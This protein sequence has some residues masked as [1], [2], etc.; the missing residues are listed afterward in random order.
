MRIKLEDI[1]LGNQRYRWRQNVL[2]IAGKHPSLR[3]YLG[4]KAT[5]FPGQ[6]SIHFR[7]LLAEIVAEAVC[8]H[9]LSRNVEASPEDYE[10]ADWDLYYAE[11]SKYMTKFLPIAHKLQCPQA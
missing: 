10:D 1:D 4:E 2:E 8:A 9:L 6:E 5:G 7:L 3:R 11:Y